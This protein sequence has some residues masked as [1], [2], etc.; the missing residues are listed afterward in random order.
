MR[1]LDNGTASALVGVAVLILM[2][3]MAKHHREGKPALETIEVVVSG[4]ALLAARDRLKGI[5]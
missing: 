3:R 2:G 1:K 4:M 5:L